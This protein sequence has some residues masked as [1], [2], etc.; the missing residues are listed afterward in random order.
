MS[1]PKIAFGIAS[2]GYAGY[3]VGSVS[4]ATSKVNEVW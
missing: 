4:S 2:V 1:N 3:W